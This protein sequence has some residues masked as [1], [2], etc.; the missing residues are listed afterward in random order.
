MK[1]CAVILMLVLLLVSL[2]SCAESGARRDVINTTELADRL[3]ENQPTPNDIEYSLERYNLI[4]RTYWVNGMRERA[5]SLPCEVERPLGYIVLFSGNAAVG[6]FVVDGKVS[7]LNS[8]L[9]PDSEYY[10]KN[11]SY[12]NR[13][14]ADVDGSYGEN[15]SGIFFFTPDGKYIEWSGDYLYSDI[16]FTIDAPIVQYKETD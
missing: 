8:F 4:R 7:S 15:D 16:P 12:N 10:E 2:C 6:Q 5:A 13:W 9:T 1:K 11:S 14:L 3:Q